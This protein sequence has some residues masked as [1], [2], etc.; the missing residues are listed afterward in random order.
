MIVKSLPKNFI[1]YLKKHPSERKD[2]YKN[3]KKKFKI[4]EIQDIYSFKIKNKIDFFIGMESM[5]LLELSLLSDNVISL[6][7]NAKQDF[8][9]EKVGM[10]IEAKSI[11]DLLNIY[12]N[13]KNTLNKNIKKKYLSQYKFSKERILKLINSNL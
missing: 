2:K 7:P 1:L 4:R 5:L 10:T 3:Y 11:N 8:I 6:R 13:K 12:S 9:G